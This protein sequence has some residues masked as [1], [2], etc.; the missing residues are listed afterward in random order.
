MSSTAAELFTQLESVFASTPDTLVEQSDAFSRLLAAVEL[1]SEPILARVKGLSF[2]VRHVALF[3]AAMC[4]KAA[5]TA[6]KLLTEEPSSDNLSVGACQLFLALGKAP[7]DRKSDFFAREGSDVMMQLM[8][9]TTK[10][11]E[12]V[13]S[14]AGTVFWE[15]AKVHPK[16]VLTKVA[17]WISIDQDDGDAA[18]QDAERQHAIKALESFVTMK[19]LQSLWNDELQEHLL[20]LLA[21][22]FPAVTKAEFTTLTQVA[23]KLTLVSSGQSLPLLK[24][25]LTDL[26]LDSLRGVE[27]VALLA[28]SL[29]R[30]TE[31]PALAEKVIAQ[32]MATNIEIGSRLGLNQAVVLSI[33]ARLSDTSNAQ[34]LTT[35]LLEAVTSV[36]TTKADE[37]IPEDLQQAEALLV[38]LCLAAAKQG[39]EL[40]VALHSDTFLATLQQSLTALTLLRN[41]FIFWIKKRRV[42]G[43]ALSPEMALQFTCITNLVTILTALVGKHLP[44]VTVTPSWVSVLPLPHVKR[45]RSATAPAGPKDNKAKQQNRGESTSRPAK[46]ARTQGK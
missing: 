9:D 14:E 12:K 6:V 31:Y 19:S 43:E 36:L 21:A 15:L 35:Q 32:K 8:L 27:A 39:Q 7:L 10:I 41:R 1:P 42:N 44:N 3:D 23:A 16:A 45:E 38:A 18:Q 2:V 20:T 46:K 30:A 34:A 5:Q 29:A 4:R 25:V 33:A 11:S 13:R 17:R 37:G 40:L 28:P 24:A 22:V 26:K